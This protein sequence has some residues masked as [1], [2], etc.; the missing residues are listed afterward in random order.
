M[1]TLGD[2]GHQRDD[3]HQPLHV[4]LAHL[5]DERLFLVFQEPHHG[6][7]RQGDEYRVDEKEVERPEEKPYLPR[8]KAE[9]RGTKGRDQRRSDRHA[10]DHGRS[11][12]LPRLRHDTS[13][14]AEQCDQHVVGRRA[15]YVPATRCCSTTGATPGNRL[16]R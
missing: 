14:A 6:I 9:A 8:G 3:H 13:Q 1:T 2:E 4:A 15:R 16:S 12:I 10:R 11:A 5:V 7:G